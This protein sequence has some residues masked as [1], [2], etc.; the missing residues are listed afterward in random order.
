VPVHFRKLPGLAAVPQAIPYQGSKRVLAHAILPL[1]PDDVDTLVE[2]FA[3]SAAVT[4]AARHTGLVRKSVIADMN[5]PL[6]GLW[7]RILHD[8]DTLADDYAA[9]WQEQLG[10][11][12][13]Y[14]DDVRAKFNATHEPHHLLYLLNRCVKAAVRYSRAGDFN[15][16]ADHRRLGAKP[17]TVRSRIENVSRTMAGSGAFES[18]YTPLLTGAGAGDVVYMDPPYQGVTNVADHR[19]MRGLTRADYEVALAEAVANDVSFIVSYDVVTHDNKYGEPLS[20]ALGL[21][22]LHVAAGRSSQATLNGEHR[23]TVESLYLSPALVARLG[24]AD[25]AVARL[26]GPVAVVDATLF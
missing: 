5:G 23:L 4:V 20:M 18:D 25:A 24:G 15:Q 1:L 6:I 2:P 26:G 12:R 14:Y 3:G 16:S 17:T 19:Y 13:A 8:P 21:T 7:G 11:P 22:H 10:D 9:M